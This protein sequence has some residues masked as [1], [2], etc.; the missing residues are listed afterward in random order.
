MQFG[1]IGFSQVGEAAQPSP[2]IWS[3]CPGETLNSN[4]E[5]FYF[6]VQ[7]MGPPTGILAAA[8]DVNMVSF[9]NALKLDADTDTVLA[10]V[11]DAQGGALSIETD[12]DDNDAA[13]LFSQPFG[14]ITKNSGQR[15]WFEAI[16]AA[17]DVDAD[18]GI[19][20]GIVEADAVDGTTT[21]ARD[22]LSN[23]VASNSLVDESLIGFVQDNGD[24]NAFDAVYKK[25]AGTL[26]NV[27]ND[28]TNATAIPLA[29]RAALTDGAFFKLGLRFDGR[30]K[31]TFYANGY[32]VAVQTVDTTI[33][34]AKDYCAVVAVK[35]GAGAAEQVHVRRVRFASKVRG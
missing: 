9:G 28:V 31:L 2:S 8:L 29:S 18:M 5:G 13:A 21:T 33:D 27:L 24:D 35:T 3:D 16:V 6:D 23:D 30:D 10:M 15:L 4:A 20:V 1:E 19:F 32:E 22:V 26:V 17:G 14:K 12:G 7:F 11:A 25:D 34:Q